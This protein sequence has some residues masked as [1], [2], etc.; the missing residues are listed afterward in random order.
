LKAE[1]PPNE[2]QRLKA[3]EQYEILDTIAGKNY[4][5]FTFLASQIC[6]TPIALISLVDSERQWFKSKVGLDPDE[7]SRELAFCAHAI[8][9]D[10]VM[11]VPNAEEDKRFADNDLVMYEPKIRFYAGAPLKNPDGFNL[12][13][14]C[15]IDQ[16]PRELS[17]DQI[18]SLKALSRQIVARME[19]TKAYKAIKTLEGLLP[20]CSYCKKIRDDNNYWHQIE[21]YISEHLDVKF[22]HSVCSSCHEKEVLPEMEFLRKSL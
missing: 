8:L 1:I 19:L 9:K 15:V 21:Q 22:S 7:T 11:I 20:I 3:L 14:L 6:Q 13:T 18:A 17:S 12:G 4:D 5:D 2:E 10:E 16:I